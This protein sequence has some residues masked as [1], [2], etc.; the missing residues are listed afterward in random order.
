MAREVVGIP[1]LMTTTQA[2]RELSTSPATVRRWYHDGKLTGEY[3]GTHL[4]IHTVSVYRLAGRGGLP[5]HE[6]ITHER[7]RAQQIRALQRW[8]AEGQRLLAELEV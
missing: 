2:A 1:L 4:R 3:A 5:G 7:E 6:E 8:L